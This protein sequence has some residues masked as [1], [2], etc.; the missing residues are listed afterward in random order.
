MEVLKKWTHNR[1]IYL[2]SITGPPGI[3]ILKLKDQDIFRKS[4]AYE[5]SKDRAKTLIS[6]FLKNVM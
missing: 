5:I 1:L 4:S 2:S 6:E 3:S